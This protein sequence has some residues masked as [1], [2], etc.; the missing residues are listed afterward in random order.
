MLG[1]LFV[2]VFNTIK[3]LLNGKSFARCPEGI[4]VNLTNSLTPKNWQSRKKR[5]GHE[6]LNSR[7]QGLMR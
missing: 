2:F 3:Y 7:L 1:F 6:H 5:Q 4:K